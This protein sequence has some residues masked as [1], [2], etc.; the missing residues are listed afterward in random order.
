MKFFKRKVIRRILA[1]LPSYEVL[2]ENENE[3]ARNLAWKT[4][5]YEAFNKISQIKYYTKSEGNL[6]AIKFDQISLF[7]LFQKS[8]A[9]PSRLVKC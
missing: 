6:V 2:R 7:D 4:L 8:L 1:K 5:L 3:T 9:V